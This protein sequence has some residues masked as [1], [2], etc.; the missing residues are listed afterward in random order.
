MRTKVLDG[1]A[2][3]SKYYIQCGSLQLIKSTAK[4]AFEAAMESIDE[5]NEYDTLDEYFYVDERGFR[6][7]VS[8]EPDTQV[9]P[10]TFVL[11]EAGWELD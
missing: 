9:F 1:V 5:L 4:D 2:I 11:K 8:A 7:Y 6:N 3:M 10:T